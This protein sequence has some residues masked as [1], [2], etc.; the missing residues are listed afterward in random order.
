MI[1]YLYKIENDPE[2]FPTYVIF[3]QC[4]P[5]PNSPHCVESFRKVNK[6]ATLFL[7]EDRYKEIR[8]CMTK[9]LSCTEYPFL[10]PPCT[11][12]IG[13]MSSDNLLNLEFRIEVNNFPMLEVRQIAR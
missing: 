12:E 1:L 5:K 6:G 4:L 8:E 10:N 3:N 9:R 13:P 2:H 7:P 11:P